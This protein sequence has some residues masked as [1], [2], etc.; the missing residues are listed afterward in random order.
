MYTNVLERITESKHGVA[1]IRH[2]TPS[3]IDRMRGAMSGQPLGRPKY[4]RLLI[5]G[6]VYMTDAEFERRT[7]RDFMTRAHGDVLIAGLGI[8]LI[9]DP[10]FE[11]CTSV[12]VIEKY[13][14]VI[15]LVAKHF[16]RATVIHAD[17]FEWNPPAGSSWDTIYFDIWPGIGDQEV[18]DGKKLERRFKRR[19][20]CHSYLDAIGLAHRGGSRQTHHL[21]G[22]YCLR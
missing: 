21:F 17:I 10:L 15:S 8:G 19:Q 2:D 5:G 12:T 6:R 9:L 13:P 20:R 16:P 11:K 22:G 4:A 3:P 7:N 18:A 1:E 14:D